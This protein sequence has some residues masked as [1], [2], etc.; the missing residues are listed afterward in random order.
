MIVL[1]IKLDNVLPFVNF[2]VSFSYPSKLR[3]SLVKNEHLKN[4]PSFRYK[5]LNI[6]V[7]SNATGKTSLIKCIW[8]TLSF[9]STSDKTY[10][11]EIVNKKYKNSKIIIDLAEDN[12][13]RHLLHR[14]KIYTTN[15]SG[16]IKIKISHNFVNLSTALSSHDSYE[17]K[18]FELNSLKDN[19]IDYIDF[20]KTKQINLYWNTILPATEK[21]FEKVEYLVRE[22]K[23]DEEEYKEILETVFKTLDPSI[24]KIEKSKDTND[25]YVFFHENAGKIIIQ[26]NMPISLIPYLSSGTKYGINIANM[27][28]SI[29]HHLNEIYLIDEQFSYVNSDVE[30]AILSLMVSMLRDNEQIFF[31]THNSNILSL[32]FPFHSF[33]FLRKE[34]IDNRSHIFISCASEV[35]NRNNVSPKMLI[36][37]DVFSTAPNLD[38]IYKLGDN[39]YE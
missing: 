9:L 34:F 3:T 19:F 25:A 39:Y 5:K 36:D 17:N 2:D 21:G 28:Y 13:F 23:Q 20:F 31:T 4:V 7:G 14:F 12:K 37:N 6:F 26:D 1:G 15:N 11:E 16:N 32:R 30:T 10:I 24:L 18:L 8:K 35:E 33:Y 29:K 27:I 22:N 38:I